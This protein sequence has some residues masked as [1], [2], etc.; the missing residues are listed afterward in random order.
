VSLEKAKVQPFLIN[1]LGLFKFIKNSNPC[2]F[3][4]ITID[5]IIKVNPVYAICA[6]QDLLLSTLFPSLSSHVLSLISSYNLMLFGPS[7][8]IVS[9]SIT[10]I[11][12]MHFTL[13]E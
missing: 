3:K 5:N 4:T 2:P 6:Q 13:I 9:P 11:M 8:N 7:I 1:W 12:F 10:H